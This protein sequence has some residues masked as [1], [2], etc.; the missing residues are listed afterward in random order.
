MIPASVSWLGD[1]NIQY[2]TTGLRT[3]VFLGS[4]PNPILEPDVGYTIMDCIPKGMTIYYP[5][6]EVER[7]PIQ[8]DDWSNYVGKYDGYTWIA[9]LPEDLPASMALPPINVEWR[10]DEETGTLSF[11]GTGAMPRNEWANLSER[12]TSIVIGEGITKIADSAFHGFGKAET[13]SLPS[14][15]TSIGEFAFYGCGI[16]ELNIPSSVEYIGEGAFKSCGE[17]RSCDIWGNISALEPVTFGYCSSLQSVWFMGEGLTELKKDCLQDCGQ[18]NTLVIPESV[19]SMEKIGTEGLRALV[20]RGEPPAMPQDPATGEYFTEFEHLTRVY[21][22]EGSAKWPELAK[23]C[24]EDVLWVEGI[25]Q[26][27][28]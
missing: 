5:D 21:Y 24:R 4:P 25:P 12:V 1:Q 27:G 14:T 6:Y 26:D 18:I 22:P 15:L 8:D 23:H 2:G 28:A 3:M 13:V 7:G 16:K 10:F 20:F 9:G 11:E 17:L 19:T